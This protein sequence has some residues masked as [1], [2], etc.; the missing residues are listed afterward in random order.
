MCPLQLTGTNMTNDHS[1]NAISRFIYAYVMCGTFLLSLS[2][3][4]S[5]SKLL[6]YVSVF[7]FVISSSNRYFW[8]SQGEHFK[9]YTMNE[10]TDRDQ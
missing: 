5:S 9:I 6:Q 10:R 1:K 4:S 7:R 3:P 8:L 2:A